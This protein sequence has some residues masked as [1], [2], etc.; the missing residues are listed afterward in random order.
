MIPLPTPGNH[1][2]TDHVTARRNAKVVWSDVSSAN[3]LARCATRAA[4]DS[5]G[6]DTF[7]GCIAREL[8]PLDDLVSLKEV[9][10]SWT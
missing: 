10:D 4:P 3:R 6:A 1:I 7:P 9:D 2:W 8:R 5:A